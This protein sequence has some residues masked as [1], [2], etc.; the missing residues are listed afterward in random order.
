MEF[1]I[2]TGV[3]GAGKTQAAHA[4]ED[5]GFY[6]VDNIPPSLLGAFYGVCTHAGEEHGKVAVVI[7]VRG[8]KDFETLSGELEQLGD[9]KCRILF[10]DAADDVLLNRYRFTRRRHPLIDEAN[11]SLEQAIA[12]ERRRLFFLRER[13]DYL[14][15]TSL[16]SGAQLKERLAA[17]FLG[18]AGKALSV[19]C[20][21]FGYKYGVP[22]EADLVFD[23]RCLPNPYYIPELKHKTGLDSEVREYVMQWD[24]SREL[25]DRLTGLIDFLLPLYTK[26]G[27]SHLTV[28]LGCTGGKHRSVTFARLLC[29]HLQQRGERVSISHRDLT[30]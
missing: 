12:M 20:M 15:D 8:G 13:A 28:A 9:Q 10:L 24:S 1:L 6:C 16:L 25:A 27:K 5:I 7:D 21:S 11:G 29:E 30:K 26:E 18:D 14:I 2:V 19:H 22:P 17:M 4:L 3:S 23:V